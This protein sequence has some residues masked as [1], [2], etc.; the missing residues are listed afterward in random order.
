[1]DL[2]CTS[3]KWIIPEHQVGFEFIQP[4]KN[5]IAQYTFVRTFYGAK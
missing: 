3:E 5:I 1:M 4:L 2:N